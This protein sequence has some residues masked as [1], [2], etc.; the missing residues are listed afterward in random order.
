MTRILL[1]E[2]AYSRIQ[3]RLHALSEDIEPITIND[4]G[5]FTL[6][7][8][9]LNE[10]DLKADAAW[11]GNDFF[12]GGASRTFGIAILKSETIKWM[13]TAAAGLD[14]SFFRNV[15]DKGVRLSNSDA[16]ARAIA[17][18]VLAQIIAHYQ[19]TEERR[20]AQRAR[21]WQRFGFREIYKTR[22]TI[23]GFGNIGSE[24]GK[25]A[26][27]FDAHVTGIRRTPGDHP[28]ADAMANLH[29]LPSL[30]PQSDVVV[31]ACPLN[32]ATRKLANAEFF[33]SMKVGATLVNIGRGG[34]V[35]ELAL[36]EGLDAGKPNFAILDVFQTE[37]LP[38][39]SPLWTHSRVAVTGHTSAFGS[40]TRERGDELFLENVER[41][42]SGER[43]RNEVDPKSL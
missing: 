33:A 1:H 11:M 18:Y 9:V 28:W 25:R 2:N 17:E 15:M 21:K 4:D 3:D 39:E 5:T 41:F 6:N 7:G 16:Q 20:E 43:L 23:I 27:G 22:W 31:L 29:A 35:D 32:E 26:R 36:V 14:N 34:L 8:A 24:I 40:G 42:L 12:R 30:V 37:P 38:E 10:A 19:P 13:Q